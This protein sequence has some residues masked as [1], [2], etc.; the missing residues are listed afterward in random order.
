MTDPTA[1]RT[2]VEELIAQALDAGD[3]PVIRSD[4]RDTSGTQLLV[5]PD[6]RLFVVF[7]ETAH[8][9]PHRPEIQRPAAAMPEPAKAGAR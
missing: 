2:D 7:P 6:P 5:D 4:G 8:L 9:L 3:R 1:S